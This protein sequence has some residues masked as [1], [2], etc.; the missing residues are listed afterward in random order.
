VAVRVPGRA[1]SVVTAGV[2][3][4]P[5]AVPTTADTSAG[6]SSAEAARRLAEVGN[7]ELRRAEATPAW[8][9]F[10][11]QLTG[12]VVLLM[13]GAAV[14]S[15]LLREV[16]DAI[17]IAAIVV[18]NAIVGFLQEYR[19]E[20][21]VLALRAMT[22]PRARVVRDGQTTG[23]AATEVVP[24]DVLVL[25]AGDIVAADAA[26]VEAHALRA[27]EAALT[28]ES[29]PVDKSATPAAADAVL[30]ER[31]DRVFLGTAIAAGTGRA[32][33]TATGMATELGKIAALLETAEDTV[34]PLQRR[35][36]QVSRMLLIAS[37]AIVGV[38][39]IAGLWH[40][41]GAFDVFLSAVSLAV[42]AVPEGLPAIV[43][44]ALALGVR[45]M[46]VRHALVRKLPAVETLGCA[47]VI[48]TDK[49]GT[50]TTGVMAVRELWGPDHAALLDAAAACCDAELA[51][52]PAAGI[53]IG[54]PTELAILA[55]A[56][57]RGIRR[58]AIERDRPRVEVEPF[59]PVARRM[60]IRRTDGAWYEK[61]AAEVVL[62]R[63]TAG[64][65]GAPQAVT[66]L[67]ARGLR[68][69]AVAV[70]ET[71]GAL[72]LRGLIGIADPPRPEAV[73]AVAAARAAGIRTV[74]IT[75][76]H[77]ATAQVIA[78]ELGIVR[79]GESPDDRVHARATPE[80]K[81]RIVRDWKA[82]GAVVAMTG[83]GV[84]DA[85]AL[86]EAH[87]GIAMGRTGT[88]VTR[89]VSDIV[90]ADDNFATIVAAI[91]EGRGIFDNIRKALVYL[92]SGNTAEL[93]VMLIA[94]LA[95]LPL[96]LL[97]LQLLWIN[98]VTDGLP[99]LALVVDPPEAD[100]MR[101]PP[102]SPSE[103]ILGRA[104]WREIAVTGA[105]QTAVTFGVFAWALDGGLARAR[106][107]AFAVL[108]F[109]Q[110]LRS[111]A[112]RS[113]T[114][115]FWQ[116]GAFSNLVLLAVVIAS[117]AAQ[118]AIHGLPVTRALFDITALAPLDA[119]LCLAL[120][121]VPVTAVELAKLV[122]ARRR[123][124]TDRG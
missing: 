26:L 61:G 41:A 9:I 115:V 4:P 99:A 30:A 113:T 39:A 45:R 10:A 2:E 12:P 97:P 96:P 14:V 112:S 57:L 37:V 44:I 25:E 50:L 75:G 65:A 123:V 119:A 66:Q 16:A 56:E 62:P 101:R 72:T 32:V 19:A 64:T 5:T 108:V 104:E 86:R 78:R 40:G 74:M 24:G 69:L 110:L 85:P 59:D 8:R 91:R 98:L 102:R 82:R 21:A 94:A 83:D 35:L 100:A 36:A 95:G 18:L 122:R 77:P 53:G 80:D 60:A 88:E 3:R 43:T 23:V 42:A 58:D 116:V 34:T 92:L 28:G 114:R 63:C 54:D 79:P 71:P 109:V 52:A 1:R 51:T 124:R 89:E 81:L 48:C 76:D 49:T 117:I 13:L 87:V 17:A 84:N 107:L 73:E 68:V 22:A 111:F 90:L 93:A 15:G 33:V 38:V 55:E 70:G 121:V 103:P 29:A 46:V 106:S 105:L 31:H 27:S 67:A 118:L 7:N 47:T 120:G 11:D 6:L 20:R